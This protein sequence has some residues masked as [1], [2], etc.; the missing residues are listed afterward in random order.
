MDTLIDNL[1]FKSIL[2]AVEHDILSVDN[3]I[4]NQVQITLC[5]QKFYADYCTNDDFDNDGLNI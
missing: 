4:R 1:H 5:W 3:L 2:V